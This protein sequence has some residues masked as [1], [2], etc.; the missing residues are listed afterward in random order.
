[1]RPARPICFMLLMHEVCL[2][3][4]LDLARAG[5]SIAARLAMIAMTTRSSIK[6]NAAFVFADACGRGAHVDTATNVVRLATEADREAVSARSGRTRR[7][8]SKS[9]PPSPRIGT[10][11]EPRRPRGPVAVPRCAC[12][13]ARPVLKLDN[14]FCI[15]VLKILQ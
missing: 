3:F 11:C 9:I 1:M 2:A 7:G 13:R 4:D 10:R 14:D 5:K 8:M 6:V 15:C 12:G